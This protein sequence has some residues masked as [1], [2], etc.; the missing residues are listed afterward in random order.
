MNRHFWG[1]RPMMRDSDTATCSTPLRH[2]R[3]SE[4]VPLSLRVLWSLLRCTLRLRR[5]VIGGRRSLQPFGGTGGGGG[6]CCGA[7]FAWR[8][9]EN[10]EVLPSGSVAV[11]V[12]K[13]SVGT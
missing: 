2:L 10:S 12:T 3:G 9:A 6:G 5:N 8:H 7:A 4:D 13:W 1:R 11:A